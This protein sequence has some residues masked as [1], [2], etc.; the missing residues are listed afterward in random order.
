MAT[1]GDQINLQQVVFPSGTAHYDVPAKIWAPGFIVSYVSVRFV[2][3]GRTG[4]AN[5]PNLAITGSPKKVV[6]HSL[7]KPLAYVNFV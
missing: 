3:K 4:L 6:H 5:F 1:R 2:S 7:K